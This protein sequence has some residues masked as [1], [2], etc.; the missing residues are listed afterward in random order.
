[1][2]ENSRPTA[3]YAEDFTWQPYRIKPLA[4]WAMRMNQ[5]FECQSLE[6]TLH[7]KAGDWLVRADDGWTYPVADEI[8]R[9]YYTKREWRKPNETKDRQPTEGNSQGNEASKVVHETNGQRKI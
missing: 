5:D 6:S 8:F 9:R 4:V 1:M 7:G 2:P 3:E